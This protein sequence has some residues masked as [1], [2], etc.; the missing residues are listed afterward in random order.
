MQRGMADPKRVENKLSHNLAY[1]GSCL[2]LWLRKNTQV[3]GLHHTQKQHFRR[4]DVIW[5]PFACGPSLDRPALRIMSRTHPSLQ[6][7]LCHTSYLSAPVSLEYFFPSHTCYPCVLSLGNFLS[8]RSQF[9]LPSSKNPFVP[10]QVLDAHI[11]SWAFSLKHS[12][13]I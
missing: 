4:P 2:C 11:A 1:Q 6:P 7:H 5:H 8:S 3:C 9:N 13:Q 10:S 12:L